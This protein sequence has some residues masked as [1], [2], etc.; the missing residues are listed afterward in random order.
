MAVWGI[1]LI[2]LFCASIHVRAEVIDIP[3]EMTFY[4]TEARKELEYVNNFRTGDEAWYWDIDGSK[5][6]INNL[7]SLKYDYNLEKVAMQRAVEAA[8]RNDNSHKRADGKEFWA[9]YDDFGYKTSRKSE[10][11]GTATGYY[12]AQL[13]VESFKENRND[14]SGQGH[15]RNMLGEDWE[16]CAFSIVEYKGLFYW[17]QEFADLN[18][19]SASFVY[20]A[21]KDSGEL[22]F[23]KAQCI[24]NPFSTQNIVLKEGETIDL[25]QLPIFVTYFVSGG[26]GCTPDETQEFFASQVMSVIPDTFS[27]SDSSVAEISGT[28]MK[29][30]KVGGTTDFTLGFTI[31]GIKYSTKGYVTV[32]KKDNL[33]NFSLIDENTIEITGLSDYGRA[34]FYAPKNV[35]EIV[36]PNEINGKKVKRIAIYAFMNM[37]F[38]SDCVVSIEDGIEEIGYKA[39]YRAQ[40]KKLV[41][42]ASIE[43]MKATFDEF[44][45]S[46]TIPLQWLYAEEIEVDKNNPNF[47]S[48]DGMLFTKDYKYLFV[49]P[50]R[51]KEKVIVLPYETEILWSRSLSSSV[52]YLYFL[53]PKAQFMYETFFQNDV[54]VFG[55]K[56]SVEEWNKT[57]DLLSFNGD[58]I[59]EVYDP[60]NSPII[61]NGISL[62]KTK[63]ELKEGDTFKLQGSLFP[64][65]VT[66]N[67]IE[68]SSDFNYIA[69][70][71]E[72]G[73][74]A[75]KNEGEAVIT[76]TA[77]DS[78]ET[79]TC[80]VTVI[81]KDVISQNNNQTDTEESQA[82]LVKDFVSRFY[83]IILNRQGVSDDEVNY[84]TSRLLSHELDGCSVAKGF[85]MSPEYTNK[86]DKDID[87]VNKMYAA[88]FNREADA[89]QYYCDILASGQSREVVLAGFVNS[90][91]FKALCADYGINPGE[92][93]VDS[94]NQG[95][96]GGN[97][98]GNNQGSGDIT[99]LNLDSLNVDPEKLDEFV[100]RL[101]QQILGR[102][103]DEGGLKYWK[104]QIM[105]GTTYDAATAAR[106]GFF[107]S[108][109]YIGKNKTNEQFVIDCYHAFLGREPEPEG[110]KYWTEKLDSG[111]YSKQKVIDLGFGHSD[112]F[113]RILEDCGFVIMEDNWIC[114]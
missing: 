15:R 3:M 83:T 12:S 112:E 89:A 110:L 73:V 53:N 102:G 32:D 79:A 86:G 50:E 63:I 106:V 8:L 13:I 101:Y 33:Y 58:V 60:D 71:D 4:Q 82:K 11:R 96:N 52:K 10:N 25:K 20:T 59:F 64:S 67:K 16:V 62:N 41:I 37:N 84:Y 80:L 26:P 21:P 108:E 75:A 7:K 24:E 61:S 95:N 74:I 100:K 23:A 97:N 47:A 65:N 39:F 34:L 93:I 111:E 14:Y 30:K 103:Y 113:K 90:P 18:G 1:F 48:K 88:F 114:N 43:V 66:Y 57:K 109:E 49:C 72:N 77:W 28:N 9:T 46:P 22:C 6:Y 105:A 87:F 35:S 31:N 78:G 98:G 94:G 91:E 68:W 99:K 38:G 5:K 45:F 2:F 92:M 76:A 104:E 42:P 51:K 19:N 44:D 36:I 55:L 69:S 56:N 40:M 107:E 27:I 17:A 85:V 29:A 70:V 81:E 54:T